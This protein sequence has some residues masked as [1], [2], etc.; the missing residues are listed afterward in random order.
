MQ[1]SL[2]GAGKTVYRSKNVKSLS[3]LDL[4]SN[5]THYTPNRE[6]KGSRSKNTR[7]TSLKKAQSYL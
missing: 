4:Q 6:W 1:G 7:A 2:G 5:I 3:K